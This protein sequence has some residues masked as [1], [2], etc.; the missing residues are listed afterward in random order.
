MGEGVYEV[1]SPSLLAAAEETHRLGLQLEHTV[2]AT[3]DI[4]GC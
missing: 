3:A 2:D 1:S 4:Q